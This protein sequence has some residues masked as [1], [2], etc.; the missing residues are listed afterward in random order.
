MKKKI[1]KSKT[2]KKPVTAPVAP[3]A[4]QAPNASAS[5]NHAS[6][7]KPVTPI[8]AER[9]RQR[10]IKRYGYEEDELKVSFKS[11]D[12]VIAFYQTVASKKIDKDAEDEMGW[13]MEDAMD[14]PADDK[15][16]FRLQRIEEQKNKF[17]KLK[18]AKA[19]V[20]PAAPDGSPAETAAPA[21]AATPELDDE[22]DPATGIS[23]SEFLR[24]GED[25][26]L[27][28]AASDDDE[29]EDEKSTVGA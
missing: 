9:A 18:A 26:E 23:M 1:A 7:A 16:R 20:A 28:M 4:P 15:N 2:V 17:A 10:L 21:V 29:D 12:E 25:I 22:V 19:P 24:A 14:A 11:D 3:V 27:L 13:D 5:P 6:N 8:S